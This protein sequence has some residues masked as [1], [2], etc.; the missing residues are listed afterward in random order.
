MHQ[1]HDHGQ[2]SPEKARQHYR[3]LGINLIVSL[4]I[5]YFVM[6]AMIASW[7]E[8]VQNINFFYM[9]L[10]MWAPM[11][12]L[13]L[14]TMPAMYPNKRLNM[15]LYA[16]FAMAFIL[17]TVGIREQSLVGDRQ[18]LRSMIPHHSGAILMCE[19]S[20]IRDAEIKRLCQGIIASQSS[21][22]ARMQAM[23][24][25]PGKMAGR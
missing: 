1:G 10:M 12:A 5:M 17:S 19:E 4:A 18:F 7:G 16:L 6:F 25:R 15:A 11:G 14:L 23:L 9:A 8:F 13:M 24:D 2:T 22:I 3:M 20:S 21:E